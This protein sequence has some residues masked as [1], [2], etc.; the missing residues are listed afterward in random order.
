M[1]PGLSVKRGVSSYVMRTCISGFRWMLSFIPEATHPLQT[2][3]G[4]R[5]G[6]DHLLS[7]M[8]VRWRVAVHTCVCLCTSEPVCIR[9]ETPRT[10]VKWA[11]C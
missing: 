8:S 7:P 4:V 9:W 11:V 5:V 3:Q 2:V 10:G 6:E 1:G